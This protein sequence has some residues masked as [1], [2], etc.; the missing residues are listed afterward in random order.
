MSKEKQV[1]DAESEVNTTGLASILGLTG[2]RVQQ[3]TQDGILKTVRRGKY[4][5]GDSVQRY[6]TTKVDAEISDEE[7]VKA[8]KQKLLSDAKLKEAKAV[9]MEA[10]ADEIKG[11]MHRAEDVE[12]ITNDM[13]FTIR[14]ALNA[15]PGRVAVDVAA[16]E[17]AAEASDVIRKEVHKIMRELADYRYDPTKYAEIVR[18]RRE[19]TEVGGDD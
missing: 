11:T 8:E 15:L 12:L 3:M 14:S 4:L 10:E 1:I 5:L 16:C 13:I 6:I 18:E 17:T 9:I 19:W 2:R 7:C